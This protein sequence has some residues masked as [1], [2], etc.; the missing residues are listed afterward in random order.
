M[1]RYRSERDDPN[2]AWTLA[3]AAVLAGVVLVHWIARVSALVL[4]GSAI[5]LLVALIASRVI[6]PAKKLPRNRVRQMRLRARLRLH[7]GS[8]HASVFEL[9]L[10]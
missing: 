2:V 9:W 5:G 8:G 6:F 4:A 3:L 10:R 7:P 1:N